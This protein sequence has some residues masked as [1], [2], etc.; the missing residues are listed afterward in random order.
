M[1]NFQSQPLPLT[2]SSARLMTSALLSLSQQLE[3][4]V[5]HNCDAA[6]NESEESPTAARGA[7]FKQEGCDV[8]NRSRSDVT[9]LSFARSAT[10]ATMTLKCS[11]RYSRQ[12]LN[13]AWHT[14]KN[15]LTK[16]KIEQEK[17]LS[18][19]QKNIIS[20]PFYLCWSAVLD[21]E[22]FS[23]FVIRKKFFST[24]SLQ[25]IVSRKVQYRSW[26]VKTS[27]QKFCHFPEVPSINY[28]SK[29]L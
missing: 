10:G 26:S 1:I 7:K 17:Y 12:V 11:E 28:I 25:E 8:L 9:R 21:V 6:R 13:D 2:S 18:S 23:L 15:A 27:H 20:L 19:R 4:R 16:L 22:A 5:G 24:S 3:L 29:N 14:T